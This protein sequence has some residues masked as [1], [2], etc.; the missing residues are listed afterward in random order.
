MLG[1]EVCS[2][3]SIFVTD[4]NLN[5]VNLPNYNFKNSLR[6]TKNEIL[7]L[8]NVRIGVEIYGSAVFD[9]LFVP[10]FFCEQIFLDKHS[11]T[12]GF[13]FRSE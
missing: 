12:I 3:M 9:V 1:G 7:V 6:K 11:T 2:F 8:E 13:R 4:F 5:Q 10:A